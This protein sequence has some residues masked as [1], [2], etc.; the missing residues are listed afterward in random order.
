MGTRDP[1]V[2]A[3]IAKSPE[4]AKPIL[5][6]IRELVHAACPEAGETM[7]WST[8]HFDYR[9]EMMCAMAAFKEHAAL[10]F[11]KAPLIK[12]LDGGGD[13][14][15]QFGRLASVKELPGKQVLSGYIKQ[16]MALNDQGVTVKKPK[17]APKPEAEVPKELAA[18]LAKNKKAKAVF[19]AFPPGHRREYCEWI[20]EA[21]RDETKT[22]RV[23]QAVEWIAEGKSRNWKY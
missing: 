6:H 21:K 8:P 23:T 18:A 2:D 9:G 14:A 4:F 15:G 17:T 16:A 10:R 22:K 7:K 1:R 11:W 3:Y 13:S 5:T 12:G 20:A 19:E